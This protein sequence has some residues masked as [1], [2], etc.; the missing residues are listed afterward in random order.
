MRRNAQKKKASRS[1]RKAE[2][3]IQNGIDLAREGGTRYD[4]D[5]L[6]EMG[7]GNTT[8]ASALL[9]VFCGVDPAEASGRGAGLDDEGVARKSRVIAAALA[10]NAPNADDPL[11]VLAAIGGFEIATMAGFYLGAAE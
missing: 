11:G 4:I 1:R 8:S 7:I 5:E 3:A 9:C 2:R 10:L 6:G